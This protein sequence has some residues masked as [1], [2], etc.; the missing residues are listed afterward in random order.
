MRVGDTLTLRPPPESSLLEGLSRQLEQSLRVTRMRAQ[1]RQSVTGR[2]RLEA[3]VPRERGFRGCLTAS[4]GEMANK[5]STS[6]VARVAGP[7]RIYFCG[8]KI[9]CR[10]LLGLIFRFCFT[11]TSRMAQSWEIHFSPRNSTTK[12]ISVSSSFSEDFTSHSQLGHESIRL[13][14]LNNTISPENTNGFG[15]H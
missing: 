2:A 9:L 11:Y 6:N 1:V 7:G 13:A 10:G 12:I 4:R 5:T 14:F 15:H 3:G 8:V